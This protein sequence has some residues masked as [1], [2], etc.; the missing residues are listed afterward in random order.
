[1]GDTM[2]H[3]SDRKAQMIAEK[4]NFEELEA[5]L[6]IPGAH[7]KQSDENYGSMLQNARN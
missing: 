5:Y 3:L 2:A 4:L 1:M 7:S 6:G